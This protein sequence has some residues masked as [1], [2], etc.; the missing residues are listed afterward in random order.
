MKNNAWSNSDNFKFYQN[1]P[2]EDFYQGA[3]EGGLDNCCDIE[4][5][6]KYINQASSILEVGAGYGRVLDY[7]I[8]T[9]KTNA[10]LYAIERVPKLYDLLKEKFQGKIKVFCDDIL[11]LD[12]LT[13]KMD[14]IIIMWASICEFSQKEQLPLL[15]KL[16]SYLNKNGRL[17]LDTIP[18]SCKT[19]S[20]SKIDNNNRII[21]KNYGNDYVYIP[22]DEALSLYAKKLQINLAEKIIYE[23]RTQKKRCLYVF[24]A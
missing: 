20:A 7:L 10:K 21:E 5:I 14:L 6:I 12:I 16:I 15:T 4:A 13:E 24:E 8:N 18:I 1:M 2:L 9:K 23:T 22:S 11:R 17:I 3:I 19:I